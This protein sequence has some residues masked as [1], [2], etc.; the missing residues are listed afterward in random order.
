MTKEEFNEKYAAYKADGFYGLTINNEHII[1]YL[2][3]LFEKVL[4][5]LVDNFEFYQI[6]VKFSNVRFYSNLPPITNAFIEKRLNEI[7]RKHETT[8]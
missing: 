7:F 5:P 6:K 1:I 8:S 4:L 2:D 3:E